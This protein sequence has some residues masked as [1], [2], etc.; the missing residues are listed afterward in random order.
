MRSHDK[1]PDDI[2]QLARGW[3]RLNGGFERVQRRFLEQVEQSKRLTKAVRRKAQGAV[4]RWMRTFGLIALAYYAVGCVAYRALEGFSVFDTF[5]FLTVTATTVGYG[6]LTPV[7]WGGRLLTVFYA[8]F[9][10]IVTMGGLLQPV[11][12][13]L[14]E[15]DRLTAWLLFDCRA[16]GSACMASL[17]RCRNQSQGAQASHRRKIGQRFAVQRLGSEQVEV[18]VYGACLHAFLS[19]I[20]IAAITVFFN[21]ILERTSLVDS[22]YCAPAHA[23]PVHA[24]VRSP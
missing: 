9:G 7:T 3:Q 23:V 22:L 4:V 13:V 19:P 16:W 5:Y 10:T 1:H 11:G 14:R 8:P 18:G 21:C 17:S 2:S 12:S 20:V 24:V 6:D 15:L